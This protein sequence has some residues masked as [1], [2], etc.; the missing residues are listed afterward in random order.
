MNGY[1]RNPVKWKVSN[2]YYHDRATW[3]EYWWRIRWHWRT[4]KNYGGYDGKAQYR[5]QLEWK[6]VYTFK[7]YGKR[8]RVIHQSSKTH[9]GKWNRDEVAER[10]AAIK[11]NLKPGHIAVIMLNGRTGKVIEG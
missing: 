4:M 1:N 10:W 7:V 8:G 5:E 6:R 11:S 3:K 2:E 9:I